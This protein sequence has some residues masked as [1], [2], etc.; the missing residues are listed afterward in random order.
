M[1]DATPNQLGH[2]RVLLRK[3]QLR[4]AEILAELDIDRDGLEDLTQD[5][6]HE[7]LEWLRGEAG[8]FYGD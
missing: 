3:L 4:P 2:I 8:E 6:I 1:P 5:E 7:V